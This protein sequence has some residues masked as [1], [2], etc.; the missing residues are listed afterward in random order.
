MMVQTIEI[1]ALYFIIIIRLLVIES[2]SACLL[3]GSSV[4]FSEEILAHKINVEMDNQLS[5]LDTNDKSAY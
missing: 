2:L 4:I 3:P 1:H 5:R